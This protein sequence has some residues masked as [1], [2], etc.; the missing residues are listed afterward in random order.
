MS[1]FDFQNVG[2]ETV[3]EAAEKLDPLITKVING[4]G[5]MLHSLL[6]RIIVSIRIEIKPMTKDEFLNPPTQ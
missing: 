5:W 4:L 1:W 3:A 2:K 6:N